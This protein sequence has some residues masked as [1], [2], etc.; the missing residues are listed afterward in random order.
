MLAKSSLLQ[1]RWR[2]LVIFLTVMGPGIITSNVDND[3]GGITTYSLAGAHFGYTFLWALIPIAIALILVQEMSARMGVVTGKGLADLIRER[4]GVKITFYLL[5]ALFGANLAN[6]IAEFAG[7]AAALEIV[8]ISRYLTVPLAAALVWLLVVKFNY[9]AVEKIFLVA[10]AFYVS[11]IITG[12]LVQPEWGAV[13][14]GFLNPQ[15][16]LDTVHMAMLVA[17]VGT[18]IAPWMQFYLQSAIVEKNIKIQDYKHSRLDVIIGSF[19]VNLVAFFIILVCAA[20]LFK[21]GIRIDSAGD[22]A[23]A[24]EPLTQN[25]ASILFAFG[26]LNAS[27][28]AASILPLSTAYVICE[29]LGWEAGVNK[30]F[31]QAPGFYGL[32]TFMIVLGAVVVLFPK[33]PLIPVMYLSQI[34]NGILLP[35]ILIFI[36][37][38][39]N[40]SKVMGDFT[41]SR[42]YNISTWGIILVMFACSLLL[43]ATGI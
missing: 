12:F 8:N 17:L 14:G 42:F 13:K 35:V 1:T 27:L 22:A 29:G 36:L 23:R 39:I 31:A 40:D 11:Y 20:T 33:L 21:Y 3:A 37:F 32:Y 4:F 34:A 15:V 30:T 19:T 28:F 10:S 25:Y 43:I 41:N 5:L 16:K 26:L 7:V 18:T 6:T 9:K 2:K 24:L 38:I